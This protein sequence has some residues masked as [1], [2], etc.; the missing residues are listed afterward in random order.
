MRLFF[1]RIIYLR[2]PSISSNFSGIF[3]EKLHLYWICIIIVLQNSKGG[4]C[5]VK[6]NTGK[7][8]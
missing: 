4:Y 3:S 2:Q 5:Y 6:C 7:G 1:K 8:R